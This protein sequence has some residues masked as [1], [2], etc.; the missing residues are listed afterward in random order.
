[1]SSATQVSFVTNTDLKDQ[2]ME[3]VKSM[4]LT[5]KAY[6]NFCLQALVRDEIEIGIQSK[7]NKLPWTTVEQSDWKS[8][9]Q[10]KT[11]HSDISLEDFAAQYIND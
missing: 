7:R 8:Y 6:L 10:E 3:K 2:A 5:L 1:M 4:G 11:E 9:Q